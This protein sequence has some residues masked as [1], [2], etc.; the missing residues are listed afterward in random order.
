[1]KANEQAEHEWKRND[2]TV[3]LRK[4]AEKDAIRHLNA[5]LNACGAS[6]DPSVLRALHQY[7][8]TAG[9][10]KLLGGVLRPE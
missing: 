4:K 2:H 8:L 9:R 10:V 6:T 7:A 1:M 3:F 5:L